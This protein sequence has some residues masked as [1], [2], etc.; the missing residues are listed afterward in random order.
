MSA[1][2]LVNVATIT[3]KSDSLLLTGTSAT[4]LLDNTASSGKV[5][6]VNS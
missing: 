2:N 6:K 5:I 3:A 4:K 1:P